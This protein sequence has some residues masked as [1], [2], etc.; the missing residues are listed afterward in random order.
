MC[1]RDSAA[2]APQSSSVLFGDLLIKGIVLGHAIIFNSD[3]QAISA[4][5]ELKKSIRVK[6]NE[7][8]FEIPLE[9][10]EIEYV[11][12]DLAKNQ[13]GA[14]IVPRES[15][16]VINQHEA[17]L[18]KI[19]LANFVNVRPGWQWTELKVEFRKKS[20]GFDSVVDGLSLIT[21]DFN[22]TDVVNEY[23]IPWG[24]NHLIRTRAD[25]NH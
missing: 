24:A 2:G 15:A 23:A 6:L 5:L 4:K 20:N 16:I 25:L 19:K 8:Y 13:T 9:K 10:I 12:Y 1:I 21:M 11:E 17:V 22:Q 14:V 7:T 18:A 3:S